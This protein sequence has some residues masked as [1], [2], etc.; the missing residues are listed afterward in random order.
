VE[1]KVI[2]KEL[3]INEEI[4]DKEIRL[5]DSNG[6]P[7]GIVPTKKAL[8]LAESKQLD[9]V[10]IA[11]QAKPPVCKIMD[12]SKYLYEISKKEKEA[13][14]NQKVINIKEIRFSPNIEEHDTNVKAKNAEKFLREG[15]KVKVTVRF[16]GRETDYSH[17][18]Q[19][20][21]KQFA[22]KLSE[23]CD[24]EKDPKLE[25]KNM[26]MILKPKKV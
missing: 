19:S 1:V 12:Y 14:K 22:E 20:L 18:G 26:I 3:L 24:V 2:S 11:Q 23:V 25:G 8:E 13:K 10:M 21:L 9:L 4:R 16:R 5:V 15:D 7:L 17:I 6:D